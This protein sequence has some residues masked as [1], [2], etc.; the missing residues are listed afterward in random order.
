VVVIL[1]GPLGVGKTETAWKLI[2]Y[3]DQAAILDCD[4]IGGNVSTFDY[5][6]PDSFRSVIES[7]AVLAKHQQSAM[8]ITDFV[9]SGVFENS[10][11]LS[12]ASSVLSEI[13][14][15]VLAY[16]LHAKPEILESR[17]NKRM[18]SDVE[19]EIARANELLGILHSASG[20]LGK[21]FDTSNHTLEKVA[22]LIWKDIQSLK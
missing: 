22:D 10:E 3:F 11:Q 7:L 2:E 17:V 1:N 5:R 21:P 15:P 12:Y 4:Y 9:V 18:N 6:N 8:G 20:D 13:S 19:R 14:K 16:L